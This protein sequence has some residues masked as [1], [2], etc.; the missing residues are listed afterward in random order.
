MAISIDEGT[1]LTETSRRKYGIVY[2]SS[3]FLS[4]FFFGTK[5]ELR[6]LSAARPSS[7]FWRPGGKPTNIFIG[8]NITTVIIVHAPLLS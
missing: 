4:F 2:L 7:S 5:Y 8:N 1:I 6:H 3:P